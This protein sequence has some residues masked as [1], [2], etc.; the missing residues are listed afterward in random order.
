[1]SQDSAKPAKG[2]ELF[3]LYL[4]TP[5]ELTVSRAQPKFSDFG[6]A[7]VS[8]KLARKGRMTSLQLERV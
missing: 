5:Q 4:R 1:M 8:Q 6:T 2:K 3:L 7:T